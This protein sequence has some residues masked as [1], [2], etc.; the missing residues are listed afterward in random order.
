MNRD[1]VSSEG[2]APR[3]ATSGLRPPV[4]APAT[5][6]LRPPVAAPATSAS[7]ENSGLIDLR[8][9]M[10]AAKA[11][12]GAPSGA[13]SPPLPGDEPADSAGVGHLAIYPLGAPPSQRPPPPPIVA[14]EP[15]RAGRGQKVFAAAAVLVLAGVL[16]GA[17]ALLVSRAPVSSPVDARSV[18][19]SLVPG[20]NTE[21]AL[22]RPAESARVTVTPPGD[23]HPESAGTHDPSAD[24][25][26]PGAGS[27]PAT[28]VRPGK[29]GPLA[30]PAKPPAGPKTVTGPKAPPVTTPKVD[31]CKGDLLCAMKRSTEHH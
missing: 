18:Q 2:R 8:A 28:P 13:M 5:S 3:G 14:P 21:Q 12:S 26:S 6:G 19:R 30:N 15:P 20:D 16:V 9:L 27:A 17:T 11:T 24:T 1:P 7:T 25:A 10:A 22:S 23:P 4:A 31:P 29:S